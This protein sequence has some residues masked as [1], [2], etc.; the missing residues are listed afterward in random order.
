MPVNPYEPPLG[1]A[2]SPPEMPS[3]QELASTIQAFLA[4]EITAFEF[5]D[6]LDAFRSSNDPVI[7]YAVEAVWH[8]YDDCDDHLVCL[9]KPE[10]GLSCSEFC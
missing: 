10:L 2:G 8:F 4:S 7:Q 6:R 3:R 5:D 9:E 1:P